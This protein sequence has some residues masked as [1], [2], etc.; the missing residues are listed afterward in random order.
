MRC[1]LPDSYPLTLP[2]WSNRPSPTYSWRLI[3]RLSLGLPMDVPDSVDIFASKTCLFSGE[4]NGLL[5]SW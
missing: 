5:I 4:E 1:F 3:N 2:A